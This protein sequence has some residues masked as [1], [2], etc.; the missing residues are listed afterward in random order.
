MYVTLT[1]DGKVKNLKVHRLMGY[2]FLDNSENKKEI[3]HKDGN[4]QNNTLDNL[5]WCT[6][7]ENHNHAVLYGKIKKVKCCNIKNGNIVNIYE[8][9]NEASKI[10]NINTGDIRKCCIGKANKVGGIYFRLYDELNFSYIKTKFDT[11]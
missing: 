1:R 10:N 5:E 4:V 8:S 6:R 9:Y 3:N 7:A 2:T 11:I